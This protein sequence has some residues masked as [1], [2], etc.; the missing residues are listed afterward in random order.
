MDCESDTDSR[1]WEVDGEVK[2][3]VKK[4]ADHDEALNEQE[5]GVLNYAKILMQASTVINH[6]FPKKSRQ[7]QLVAEV[8]TQAA[9]QKIKVSAAQAKGMLGR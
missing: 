3:E 4:E 5:T 8:I 1:E 2:E 7:G 6:S 9:R